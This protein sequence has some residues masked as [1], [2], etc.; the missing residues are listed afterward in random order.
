M[1]YLYIL[2]CKDKKLY[3]GVTNNI[4][5]RLLEHKNKRGGRYTRAHGAV[6][7]VY[8]EK[9]P[10]RTKALRR[11]KEI[12]SWRREKKLKLIKMSYN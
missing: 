1:C 8:K 11:E 6:K 4:E 9:Y 3:T 12:K 7:I 2:L 10:T 5:R